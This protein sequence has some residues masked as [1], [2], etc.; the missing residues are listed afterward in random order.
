MAQ[1]EAWSAE[2]LSEDDLPPELVN[3]LQQATIACMT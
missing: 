1:M 3:G 2:G